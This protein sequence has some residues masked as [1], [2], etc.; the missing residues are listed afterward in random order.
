MS[1]GERRT[2]RKTTPDMTDTNEPMT[3][4]GP[5]PVL[6]VSMTSGGRSEIDAAGMNEVRD[7]LEEQ[8][9]DDYEIVVADDRVRLATQE[10]LREMKQA[11]DSLL[12]SEVE[13][14]AEREDRKRE[15]IGLSTDDVMGGNED[16]TGV[17]EAAGEGED[18]E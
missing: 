17:Q 9:G 5:K 10:D 7:R 13:T 12:P 8:M 16:A 14:E 1:P 6:W 18:G 15:E 2:K 4:G 11:L 3:D